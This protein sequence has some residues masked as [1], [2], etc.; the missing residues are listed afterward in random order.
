[1]V[2][3]LPVPEGLVLDAATWN[4]TPLVVQQLVIHLLTVT[5]QQE[6]RIKTL[7][8]RLAALEA[9]GQQNSRN[10]DRPP[11]SDPPHG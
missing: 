10:S 2:A 7:E 8:A 11:S 5:R 9:R 4:R 1:V 6:E 3:S